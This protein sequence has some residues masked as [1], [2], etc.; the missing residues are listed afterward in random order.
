M[1]HNRVL[2]AD[3]NNLFLERTGAILSQAGV[4]MIAA[5]N[6]NRVLSLFRH[7]APDV[8]LLHVD[9][10]GISGTEVCQRIKTQL[11]PGTPVSLMFPEEQADTSEIATRCMADNYL[12]R[13]L[14]R[15]E[16]LFCVRS[17]LQ[18]RH[19][20][21]ESAAAALLAAKDPAAGSRS[22]AMVS[23]D[24]LRTFLAL[25]IQRVERYGFPLALLAISLDPLPP[26]AASLG[27]PLESQLGPTLVEAM[28]AALRDIDLS[29]VLGRGKVLVVMPHTD[30]AGAHIA[31]D[32]ICQAIASQAYNFGRT[33]IQPTVSV[34]VACLHGEMATPEELLARV[35][36]SRARAA[37]AGGN[38]VVG[39]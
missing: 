2:V 22:S 25:E 35:E 18:L 13:P 14:K 8:A 9:L 6:G 31:A 3:R 16:L 38:R 30:T 34:G 10:A 27:K 28:R 21:K 15:T 19:H 7:D 12:V 32:R 4:E 5:S 23:L 29:A 24:L 37:A 11:D 20:L 36:A 17:L 26:E 33:Q 1:G 39:E